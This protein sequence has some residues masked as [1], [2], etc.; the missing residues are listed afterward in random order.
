MSILFSIIITIAFCLL[1]VLT[2]AYLAVRKFNWLINNR[3]PLIFF[4][5]ILGVAIYSIGYV[6]IEEVDEYPFNIFSAGLNAIFSTG[7]MFVLENDYGELTNSFKGCVDFKIAF[8]AIMVLAM[9]TMVI[10]VLSL[11]GFGFL[12]TLRIQVL[13]L[14]GTHRPVYIFT[15]ICE[16]TMSLARDIRKSDSHSLI[17]FLLSHDKMDEEQDNRLL[18]K[19]ATLDNTY[20]RISDQDFE[21]LNDFGIFPSLA[22]TQV[23]FVALHEDQVQNMKLSLQ[24]S[25]L[26]KSS[27][28][29]DQVTLYVLTDEL[30]FGRAFE[31]PEISGISIVP[32]DRNALASH[33]L[34]ERMPILQFAKAHFENGYANGKLTVMLTG[35]GKIVSFLLRDII[36]QGQQIGLKLRVILVAED[37][38]DFTAQF[39]AVNPESKRYAALELAEVKPG[40]AQFLS[41]YKEHCRDTDMVVCTGET[42]EENAQLACILK[43]ISM[44][45]GAQTYVSAH[46]RTKDFNKYAFAGEPGCDILSFGEDSILEHADVVIN[47]RL[48]HMAKAV[49][50]YYC[51]TYN[52]GLPWQRLS[53]YERES[54]RALA[55]HI[56]TK[57]F[58]LDMELVKN[59]DPAEQRSN[60]FDVLIASRPDILENLAISEHMRWCAHLATHGWTQLPIGDA[61]QKADRFQRKHPCMADWEELGRISKLA[62][63]DYQE[64]DRALIRSLSDIAADGGMQIINKKEH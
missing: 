13:R 55:M 60:Q 37:A 5:V 16:R 38:G 47:E 45:T 28:M 8:G 56:Q 1:I 51:K 46:L 20:I 42:D 30:L 6:T 27:P 48:D 40:S 54:S 41:M 64:L 36:T 53:M 21:S 61:F 3:V 25:N 29:K 62:G 57:L 63:R 7:R 14:F 18:R 50:R 12:S 52:G 19:V 34:M 22:K 24:L 39:L 17:L 31:S 9:L 26:L 35:S 4:V 10:L 59:D 11:F 44:E 23:R 49:H 2:A 33:D 43:R 15:C 58:A 32:L